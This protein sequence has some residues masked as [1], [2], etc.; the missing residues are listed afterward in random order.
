MPSDYCSLIPVKPLRMV[1]VIGGL[2]TSLEEMDTRIQLTHGCQSGFVPTANLHR[3]L[4][5]CSEGAVRA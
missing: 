1:A 5:K 4:T 2:P 3:V